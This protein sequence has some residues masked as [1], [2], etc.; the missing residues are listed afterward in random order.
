MSKS[1]PPPPA[2]HF[3]KRR[4]VVLSVSAFAIVAVGAFTGAMLK[5]DVQKTTEVRQMQSENLEERLDR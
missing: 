5:T 1:T 2:P 4:G 3:L